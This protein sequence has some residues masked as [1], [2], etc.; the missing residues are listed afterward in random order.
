MGAPH[1]ELIFCNVSQKAP[2]PHLPR[3]LFRQAPRRPKRARAMTI[4][5]RLEIAISSGV[6]RGQDSSGQ[7]GNVEAAPI[8]LERGLINGPPWVR[9]VASSSAGYSLPEASSGCTIVEV[10][11][12]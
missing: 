4:S 7:G 8:I 11:I 9:K 5:A 2:N 3:G 1:I 10:T 12:D 6:R